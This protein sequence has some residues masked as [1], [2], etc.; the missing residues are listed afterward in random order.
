MKKTSLRIS[1]VPT[2]PLQYT[3]DRIDGINDIVGT[4]ATLSDG[5]GI[6]LKRK[7]PTPKPKQSK[8]KELQLQDCTGTRD[9]SDTQRQRYP[10]RREPRIF[11]NRRL[12]RRCTH[13]LSGRGQ[14]CQESQGLPM[15]RYEAIFVALVFEW[16][17]KGFSTSV[18]GKSHGLLPYNF[19]TD[20]PRHNNAVSTYLSCCLKAYRLSRFHNDAQRA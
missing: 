13:S 15:W 14:N 19:S 2:S 16:D 18:P 1:E 12:G 9:D 10:C 3:A 6:D 8:K 4:D 11:S 7:C 5:T 20:A 17:G